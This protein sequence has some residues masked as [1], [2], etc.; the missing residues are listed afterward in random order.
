[1]I[2][3]YSPSTC[4]CS[5]AT[6]HCCSSR[7]TDSSSTTLR[8]SR[9]LVWI[10]NRGGTTKG[11]SCWLRLEKIDVPIELLDQYLTNPLA[12]DLMLTSLVWRASISPTENCRHG[13]VTCLYKECL[14]VG[15]GLMAQDIKRNAQIAEVCGTGWRRRQCVQDPI[16]DPEPAVPSLG[17]PDP[18]IFHLGG[19]FVSLGT[20]SR[21]GEV[22][23]ISRV[24][25]KKI[26]PK[27]LK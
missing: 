8:S 25:C 5:T 9:N 15:S 4:E 14:R 11:S 23:A 21:C 3:A 17:Y 1:M 20:A 18:G 10:D 22:S 2:D 6:C 16:P 19:A 26:S 24:E 12:S 27:S 13:T 7:V